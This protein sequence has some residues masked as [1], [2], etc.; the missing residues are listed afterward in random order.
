MS[1]PFDVRHQALSKKV[2]WPDTFSGC[3]SL[4]LSSILESRVTLNV[5]DR[6]NDLASNTFKHP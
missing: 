4:L 3:Y 5:T 6:S 2:C 1:W